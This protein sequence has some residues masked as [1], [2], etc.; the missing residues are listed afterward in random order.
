MEQSQESEDLR[1][2]GRP[3]TPKSAF[4]KTVA[5]TK[6]HSDI[7]LPDMLYAKFLRSPHAHAK[8]RKIDT[9]RAKN[10]PG[11]HAIITLEDVPDEYIV[12]HT[13]RYVILGNEIQ[14]PGDRKILDRQVRFVGDYVAAVAAVD[15]ETAEKAVKLIEVEYDVLPTI[16]DPEKALE[17]DAPKVYLQGNVFNGSPEKPT[18]TF[19]KGDAISA[20]EKADLVIEK[21]YS[22]KFQCPTPME[23]RCCIA[24]WEGNFLT[25]WDTIQEPYVLRKTMSKVFGLPEENV[26]IDASVSGG[27]FGGRAYPGPHEFLL[28]VLSK[29]TGRPVKVWFSRR[30]ET[31]CCQLRPE[32]RSFVKA[33]FKNDGTLVAF[34][35]KFILNVGAWNPFDFGVPQHVARIATLLYGKCPNIQTDIFVVYTNLPIG[36]GWRSFGSAEANFAVDQTM[37]EAASKL[38]I[39]P[40]E[41]RKLNH[42]TPGTDLAPMFP[43]LKMSSVGLDACLDRGAREIGWKD[44]RR[45]AASV[46]STRDQVVRGVGVAIG[47]HSGGIRR[48]P[49]TAKLEF[50]R[51]GK[52]LLRI[53]TP[54]IG[55]EQATT[56]SQI[57]AETLGIPPDDITVQQ[58]LTED[59]VED[60]GIIGSRSTAS[61]GWANVRACKAA[62]KTL[63]ANASEMLQES[64]KGLQVDGRTIISKKSGRKVTVAEVCSYAHDKGEG[65]Q[66]EGL[67]KEN[68]EGALG[69]AAGFAEVEVDKLTGRVKVLRYISVQDAGKVVN[70]LILEGQMQGAVTQGLG[71]AMSEQLVFDPKTGTVLNPSFIEYRVPTMLD[72][73]ELKCIAIDGFEPL[74]VY[75]AKGGG[76]VSITAVAPA[77]CNAVANALGA[78]SY[79]IPLTPPVVQSISSTVEFSEKEP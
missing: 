7:V 46:K 19:V 33:G 74:G 35:T 41:I 20:F 48:P 75:G 73:P 5:L 13:T 78:R 11:V 17:P 59:D 34:Q 6:Y 10:L 8:I 56:Q 66:A 51:Q 45:T 1:Y 50:N 79:E 27:G 62:R 9:T 3:I 29:K 52:V 70:P 21:K 57:A 53:G 77:I 4:A 76:E 38:S 23:P 40:I 64:A 69:F 31:I 68:C 22:S 47:S 14:I 63:L 58:A 24:S 55:T 30:E 42:V 44:R 72:L 16:F 18:L 2:V 32:T 12:E 43:G 49:A 65:I 39:D 15:E 61:V 25:L 36:G 67:F 54:D 71:Y 37:D 60:S 26:R 28:A